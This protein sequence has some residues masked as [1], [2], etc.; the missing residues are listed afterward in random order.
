V[1][2]IEA[3]GTPWGWVWIDAQGYGHRSSAYLPRWYAQGREESGWNLN[4]DGTFTS[5]MPIPVH[6]YPLDPRL[7]PPPSSVASPPRR[8]N[9]LP[10]LAVALALG[11]SLMR[12]RP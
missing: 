7:P 5:Q 3:L 2:Y 10:Y 12:G 8:G 9:F 4:A 6:G 11:Y 1:G